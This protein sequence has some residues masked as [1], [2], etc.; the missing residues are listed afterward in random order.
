VA[1]KEAAVN[2]AGTVIDDGVLKAALALVNVTTAPP[3][4]AGWDRFTVQV[5][6]AFGPRIVGLHRSEEITA[7]AARL[8]VVFAE[9]PL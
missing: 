6:A 5:M 3:P 7:E 2:A 4:G 8:T 9:L 1:L